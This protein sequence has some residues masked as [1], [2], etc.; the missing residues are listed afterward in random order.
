VGAVFTGRVITVDR[1]SERGDSGKRRIR[2]RI[3]EKFRGDVPG[4]GGEVNVFTDAAALCG[5]PFRVGREYFVYARH[6]Q[7]LLTT[8]VCSRTD[9]VERAQRDLAYARLATNGAAPPGRIVG[10]VR[11]TGERGRI[12]PLSGIPI[13]FAAG[14]LMAT[15]TTDAGG[16]YAVEPPGAGVY[17]LDVLLPETQFSANAGQHVQ[18]PNRHG[19]SEINL[20]VLYDGRVNGRVTDSTDKGI[21]GLTVSYVRAVR[22]NAPVD[23]RRVLTRDDGSFSLQRLSPGPF[24]IRAEMPSDDPE[25]LGV[26]GE[27]VRVP[28]RSAVLRPGERLSLQPLVVPR[29]LRLARLEGT[30]HDIGG[31][32]AANARVFLKGGEGS[33]PILGEPAVTDSL[34][35]FLMAVVEGTRYDVFAE[36]QLSDRRG[37]EFSDPVTFTAVPLMS[38]VR[39]SLRRR[40]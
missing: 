19:C 9:L 5:F 37:A 8:S 18:F 36:R 3:V 4:A 11:L 25:L 16:R 15:A 26:G 1:R 20:D 40:F 32:P 14:G 27:D 31:G 6:D 35:R 17:V 7:G 39:L 21:G 13:V 23:R 24:V 28:A 2:L 30:V 22:E 10:E 38:P 33:A 34:G 29:W 12:K